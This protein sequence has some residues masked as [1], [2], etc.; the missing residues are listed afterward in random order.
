MTCNRQ[1]CL[2][3]CPVN[4][5]CPC[6]TFSICKCLIIW[7]TVIMFGKTTVLH[8]NWRTHNW[9]S[10]VRVRVRSHGLYRYIFIL[11]HFF[12]RSLDSSIISNFSSGTFVGFILE[13]RSFPWIYAPP[14][15]YST[16]MLIALQFHWNMYS[17]EAAW[18]FKLFWFKKNVYIHEEK[19]HVYNCL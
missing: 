17:S 12:Q 16:T 19:E 5:L 2:F 13:D 6:L 7:V 10:R 1:S 14:Q 11:N 4:N 18:S 3:S 8:P 9:Y 15:P